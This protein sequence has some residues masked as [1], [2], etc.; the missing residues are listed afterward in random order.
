MIYVIMYICKKIISTSIYN[1]LLYSL[2]L[3]LPHTRGKSAGC[4]VMPPL[5]R[6]PAHTWVLLQGVDWIPL[7][8]W[9]IH[10]LTHQSGPFF[11]CRVFWWI[12]IN[13]QGQSGDTGFF[14]HGVLWDNGWV[15]NWNIPQTYMYEYLWP[16]LI[17]VFLFFWN[18][19]LGYVYHLGKL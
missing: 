2:L 17:V 5:V 1:H 9:V 3:F 16:R 4:G 15:W 18:W 6:A 8:N 12:F 10:Y 7:I 11:C 13:S 19:I 14:G